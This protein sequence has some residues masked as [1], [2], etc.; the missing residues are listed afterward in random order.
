MNISLLKSIG[1]HKIKKPII[2]DY[3]LLKSGAGGSRTLVQTYPPKAFYMLIYAL[4]CRD[5]ARGTTNQP[6]PYP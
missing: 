6:G 4:G 1:R 3:E 2:I 5:T